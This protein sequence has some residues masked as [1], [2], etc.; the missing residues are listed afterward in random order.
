MRD[1][2]PVDV[3]LILT[4]GD[5]QCGNIDGNVEDPKERQRKHGWNRIRKR[6]PVNRRKF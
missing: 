4:G 5:T 2:F 1:E 3:Q 6:G